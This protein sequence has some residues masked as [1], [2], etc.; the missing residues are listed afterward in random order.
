MGATMNISE[1]GSQELGKKLLLIANS[2]NNQEL[3]GLL[4]GA[5]L[6]ALSR[7]PVAGQ[8]YDALISMK[9]EQLVAS[10][11]SMAAG[12]LKEP[13]HSSFYF[14]NLIDFARILGL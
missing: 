9:D 3:K 1:A 4:S 5:G 14:E 11:K 13:P 2:T 8:L 12:L 10:I 6:P 7:D